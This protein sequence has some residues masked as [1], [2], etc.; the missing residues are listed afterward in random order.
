MMEEE[1]KPKGKAEPKKQMPRNEQPQLEET[2]PKG[3][4]KP[5]KQLP[6]NETAEPAEDSASSHRAAIMPR[7]KYAA[8]P[9]EQLRRGKSQVNLGDE[10]AEDTSSGQRAAI[11]PAPI[12]AAEE[13]PPLPA[14]VGSMISSSE[15][16]DDSTLPW[17]SQRSGGA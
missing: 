10:P 12:N 8:A 5:K 3:K 1:T 17:G 16:S 13:I 6:R 4:A 11:M 9:N 15:D 2:M 7:S 14:L